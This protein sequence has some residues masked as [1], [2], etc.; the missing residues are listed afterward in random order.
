MKIHE[1]FVKLA[2]I[3]SMCKLPGSYM[4]LTKLFLAFAATTEIIHTSLLKLNALCIF[5]VIV[6]FQL[7]QLYSVI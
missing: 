7:K 5:I 1:S 2:D 4:Q 6:S 3:S